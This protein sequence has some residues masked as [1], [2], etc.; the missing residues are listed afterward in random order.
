MR[1]FLVL[2]DS[3]QFCI[4]PCIPVFLETII[5]HPLD[6]SL[7]SLSETSSS[8]IPLIP[9][10]L[11]GQQQGMFCCSVWIHSLKGPCIPALFMPQHPPPPGPS[12]DSWSPRSHHF[13]GSLAW[14]FSMFCII[15]FYKRPF[16]ARSA[17]KCC[18]QHLNQIFQ[19]HQYQKFPNLRK[20]NTQGKT[21]PGI[22][23][24]FEFV[25][26]LKLV[27]ENKRSRVCLPLQTLKNGKIFLPIQT[28]LPETLSVFSM[29]P[30]FA[31]TF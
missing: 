17:K 20:K 8:K 6:H 15:P 4:R 29:V 11:K 23:K 25:S 19:S 9:S 7:E 10:P 12:L 3:I 1:F 30:V 2:Y 24:I 16:W 5:F 28:P 22:L 21:Y 27:V 31:E 18:L 26:N 13:K 14:D